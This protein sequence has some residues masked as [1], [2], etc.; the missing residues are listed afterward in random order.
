M[1]ALPRLRD[2][3]H[4]LSPRL[5][6]MQR[7]PLLPVCAQPTSISNGIFLFLWHVLCMFYSAT[8]RLFY[9]SNVAV[10]VF[11]YAGRSNH[12][13]HA[14]ATDWQR[15]KQV[16]CAVEKPR[17]RLS[18]NTSARYV[19]DVRVYAVRVASISSESSGSVARRSSVSTETTYM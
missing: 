2:S 17:P 6:E 12:F 11:I 8:S 10:N 4:E 9:F 18:S 19:A 3:H 13:R 14:F 7:L 16:V 5:R 1:D 15:I